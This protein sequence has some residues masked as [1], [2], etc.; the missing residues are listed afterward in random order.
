MKN[1]SSNQGVTSLDGLE[2]AASGEFFEVQVAVKAPIDQ[3]LTYVSDL[4]IGAGARVMVELG[5]RKTVGVVLGSSPSQGAMIG[6]SSKKVKLKP[7]LSIVDK[8]PVF[9][10]TMIKIAQWMA[11]YYFHPIGEVFATMLPGSLQ[12]KK[13]TTIALTEKGRAVREDSESPFRGL[14]TALFPKGAVSE[15]TA[16]K[17]IKSLEASDANAPGK[18][19]ESLLE[20]GLICRTVQKDLAV[21]AP[22]AARDALLNEVKQNASTVRLTSE[23][24]GALAL[25]EESLKDLQPVLLFGL[26]GSGKTEVYLQAIKKVFA[27]AQAGG[28]LP[29]MLMLVPEI[30][31]TP[32][33]TD[34][35]RRRFPDTVAVVHSQLTPAQRWEQFDRIR[36]NEAQILIGPRSAVFGPFQNLK[37]VIV[38]EEHDS[39]Y[40]QTSGLCYHGRDIAI[41]RGKLDG[42]AVVLGSATP[43]LESYF[44]ALHNKYK[45]AVLKQ[46]ATGQGLPKVEIVGVNATKPVSMVRLGEKS[47]SAEAVELPIDQAILDEIRAN[48]DKKQQSIVIV[49]R[50]GFAYYLFSLA[51]KKAVVCPSCTISLTVHHNSSLLRCHYCNY[52]TSTA[53]ILKENPNDRFVTVG[54]GSQQA[55][56]FLNSVFPDARIQ[57][58]DSD[59][60]QNREELYRILSDFRNQKIDILV[61]TQMLAK[62]HDFPKVTLTVILEADEILNLPDFRAGERTFQLIV[63]AAGRSGRAELEGKVMIQTKR[64]DHPIVMAGTQQNFLTFAQNELAFRKNMEYPPFSKC[65]AF[66]LMTKKPELLGPVCRELEKFLVQL[67]IDHPDAFASVRVLGPAIPGVEVLRG[68]HRRVLILFSDKIGNLRKVAKIVISCLKTLPS[69]IKTRI[70]VD[71]ASL[72]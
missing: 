18:T 70:D 51:T 62:G 58:V 14:L 17:R 34:V 36:N 10:G 35:F 59:S 49:N 54:Y 64:P 55:H 72:S 16:K 19:L 52:Q 6:T 68:Y 37:L 28:A 29:Q 56:S 60:M 50:R 48:L 15:L 26:T 39:S 42:A 38:D 9:S 69:N 61:G 53:K 47:A 12:K 5:R 63:Q 57:R 1:L 33:M 71:P 24:E 13:K 21:R 32:Q 23:Q 4:P 20:A 30:S 22:G 8:E 65:V 11:D 7:V 27:E 66:E 41:L 44:N 43:S 67:K 3:V 2:V 45:L 46:R 40:K 25:I 31:L